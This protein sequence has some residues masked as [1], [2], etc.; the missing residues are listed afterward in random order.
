MDL[1]HGCRSEYG[2]IELRIETTTSLNDFIVYV[3]DARKEPRTV[4]QQAVQCTLESAKDYA[5]LR[6][7]EYLQSWSE[8][9]GH[10]AIWRCS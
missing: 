8:A 10:E 9:G 3:Q 5:V 7:Q 6:A 1:Q 2:P 4:Y